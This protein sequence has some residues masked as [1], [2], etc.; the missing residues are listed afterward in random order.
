[1]CAWRVGTLAKKNEL[2]QEVRAN[3]LPKITAWSDE[4][5]V[6]L[7]SL[8]PGSVFEPRFDRGEERL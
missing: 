2:W 8:L 6:L 7:S 3:Y 1:M 4:M 5:T